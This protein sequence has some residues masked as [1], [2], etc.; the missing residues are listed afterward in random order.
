MNDL[1]R[2]PKAD[3]LLEGQALIPG[4][5]YMS[6]IDLTITSQELLTEKEGYEAFLYTLLRYWQM[7]RC[8]DLTDILSGGEYVAPGRPMDT[9]FWYYWLDALTSVRT[10]GPPALPQV[11]RHLA[12]ADTRIAIAGNEPLTEQEGYEAL[13]YTLLQ[14]WENT[15]KDDLTAILSAG[16]YVEPDTPADPLIWYAWREAIATVRRQ[17]PPPVKEVQ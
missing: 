17:G 15:G 14:Y 4:I 16:A 11:P 9:A 2:E 13:L 6:G 10:L 3:D 1:N 12:P 5:D 7:S 8:T